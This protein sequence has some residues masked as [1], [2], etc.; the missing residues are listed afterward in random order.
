MTKLAVLRNDTPDVMEEIRVRRLPREVALATYQKHCYQEY[1][2]GMT[3][4]DWLEEAAD[5]LEMLGV[6]EL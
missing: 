1:L 5:L 6:K 4:E 2:T 3:D